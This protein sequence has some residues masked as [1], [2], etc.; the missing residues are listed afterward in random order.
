MH[1]CVFACVCVFR[2]YFDLIVHCKLN[3]YLLL[4]CDDFNSILSGFIIFICMCVCVCVLLH[5]PIRRCQLLHCLIS[6]IVLMGCQLSEV[7]AEQQRQSKGSG[8]GC[9]SAAA[10]VGSFD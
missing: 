1:A 5:L 3:I 10:A 2:F 7:S 8:S 6:R 4:T 9:G